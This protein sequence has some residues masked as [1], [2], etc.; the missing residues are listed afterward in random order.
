VTCEETA[1]AINLG[2]RN[3]ALKPD[4]LEHIAACEHCL[5][6]LWLFESG[7]EAGSSPPD[8]WGR[9]QAAILRDL[10]PVRPLARPVVY[11]LTFAMIF[12]AALAAALTPPGSAS[13][14]NVLSMGQ[15]VF[16]F[17]VLAGCGALLTTSLVRQMVPGSRDPVS[18]AAL[19]IGVPAVM[20]FVIGLVF[21]PQNESEF[22]ANGAMCFRVGLSYSIPAALALLIPLRRGAMLRPWLTGAVLGGFAGLI[23]LSILEINCPD[24]NFNH[25]L[26][27][28]GG[29]VVASS[30]SG[31]G[32]CGLFAYIGNRINRTII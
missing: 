23:G 2:P 11:V 15:K 3:A 30:L 4:A 14:W 7:P 16:V 9:I 20:A 10:K 28:H 13:G 1:L 18:P 31:A 24:L 17:S 25:I 5:R 8:R 19:L 12:L 22:L 6:L 29:V 27:W 26:V 21:R 32:L